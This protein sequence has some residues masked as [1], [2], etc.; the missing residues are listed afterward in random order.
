M[1]LRPFR[2][3]L[4]LSIILGVFVLLRS[5]LDEIHAVSSGGAAS[6]S[7]RSD[8]SPVA[9]HGDILDHD[10]F[11]PHEEVPDLLAYDIERAWIYKNDRVF[12]RLGQDLVRQYQEAARSRETPRS[13]FLS[14][15]AVPVV[16]EQAERLARH[17]KAL[18]FEGGIYEHTLGGQLPLSALPLAAALPELRFL[19]ERQVTT[20]LG[21]SENETV[22]AFQV[23]PLRAFGLEGT[24]VRIGIISDS[25]NAT[26]GWVDDVRSGDL[27]GP[28]NAD[29][30]TQPVV[31]IKDDMRDWVS[32]EGRAMAQL[33]FDIAPRAELYFHSA[34]NNEGASDASI[35]VAIE[36]LVAAD[37]DVVVDDVGILTSALF[38]ESF[39][40]RAVSR[41]TQTDPR[42]LY[43]SATGNSGDGSFRASSESAPDHLL[44]DAETSFP[45]EAIDWVPGAACD[46]RLRFEVTR[47][48]GTRLT[49]W[50]DDPYLTLSPESGGAQT[51][52][53][54]FILD[55]ESGQILASSTANNLFT[56][57]PVEFLGI[58]EPG[59]YDLL[60]RVV[61]GPLPRDVRAL[62]FPIA[63][64]SE[65]Y[66]QSNATT[67]GHSAADGAIAVGAAPYFS[68]PA[69]GVNPAEPERFSSHGPT[70]YYFDGAGRRLEEPDVREV[71][72]LIAPDGDATTMELFKKFYG[73]SAAAPNLAASFA[74]L[75]GAFP[76]ALRDDL[77]EAFTSTALDMA[78]PGYD[79]ETG[80]GFAQPFQAAAY[81]GLDL[82]PVFLQAT[83]DNIT[84]S[85]DEV[86]LPLGT[87]NAVTRPGLKIQALTLIAQ[88]AEGARPGDCL[89][90]MPGTYHTVDVAVDDAILRVDGRPAGLIEG[91]KDRRE[92]VVIFFSDLNLQ[93]VNALLASLRL[94]N[95]EADP[96]SGHR[97]VEIVLGYAEHTSAVGLAAQIYPDSLL[98]WQR[99]YFGA[100]QPAE[101]GE[102]SSGQ[103]ADPDGDGQSNLLEYAFGTDPTDG[104]DFQI[105]W[106][107]LHKNV[108][109]G[110][111]ALTASFVMP[112]GRNDL[113]VSAEWSEDLVHWTSQPDIVGTTSSPEKTDPS[114]TRYVAAA[115]RRDPTGHQPGFLRFRIHLVAAE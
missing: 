114:W 15:D 95:A 63:T 36:A 76:V 106:M 98:S 71:P 37:C 115:L 101:E 94:R 29:G 11:P 79:Y 48:G 112:P 68:T 72:T 75:R 53:D 89:E 14:V 1:K 103:Q 110:D 85:S 65:P 82:P 40:G 107:G 88:I 77:L 31:I 49:L 99:Q 3:L 109:A 39:A 38:Q 58:D 16:P 90:V 24:G 23:E 35:A 6:A 97:S 78:S 41:A 9:P 108:L 22:H 74:L 45:V 104:T 12:Q 91:G 86:D 27:P 81:L 111:H 28:D 92:L 93:A 21:K 59:K 26:G 51:D 18:G 30:Y 20:H 62:A 84:G 25:F 42:F 64:S 96:A 60:V 105:P 102:V 56:G 33:I 83:R 13:R 17:L 4:T 87:L 2:V 67:W 80:Y 7:E 5:R 43:F 66:A 73:T 57:D 34:F 61:A 52:L 54:A 47:G 8:A 32:D 10:P 70:V 44:V 100:A 69:Y 113:A 46:T 19:R 55:P 50:W